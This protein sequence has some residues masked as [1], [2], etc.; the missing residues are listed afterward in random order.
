MRAVWEDVGEAHGKIYTSALWPLFN[1]SARLRLAR[2]AERAGEGGTGTR[3][4]PRGKD[5]VRE[6]DEW[7]ELGG[8]YV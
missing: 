1:L 4:P 8:L 7:D 5:V 6:D 3:T 2:R